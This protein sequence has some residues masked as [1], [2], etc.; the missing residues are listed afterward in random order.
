MWN[1]PTNI[2]GLSYVDALMLP[3]RAGGIN[4]FI[5][6]VAATHEGEEGKYQNQ[7]HVYS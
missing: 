7:K 1:N 6:V 2:Y 3:L 4:D 5:R